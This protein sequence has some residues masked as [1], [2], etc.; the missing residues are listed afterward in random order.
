MLFNFAA[1]FCRNFLHCFF[2]DHICIYACLT[3]CFCHYTHIHHTY[4][5][6]YTYTHCVI[7]IIY[8][9]LTLSCCYRIS[10]HEDRNTKLSQ[11]QESS[12][13][14]YSEWFKLVP[15]ALSIIE[16]CE[17]ETGMLLVA[18]AIANTISSRHKET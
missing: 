4:I 1:C 14:L 6:T 3:W 18:C 17:R 12:C 13:P 5:H 15:L 2:R 11:S 16:N 10:V 8:T 7:A 9:P